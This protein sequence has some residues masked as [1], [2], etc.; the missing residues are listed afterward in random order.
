MKYSKLTT[1]AA[2]IGSLAL[3]ACGSSD[4][5]G[6]RAGAAPKSFNFGDNTAT[7]NAATG[8]VT[9]DGA[10]ASQNGDPVN[11]S[12]GQAF[13]ARSAD[14][15]FFTSIAGD[16]MT[17]AM[18]SVSVSGAKR[19]GQVFGTEGTSNAPNS[20][21]ATYTGDY[22]GTITTTG[23]SQAVT[24]T[25]TGDVTIGAD[26]SSNTFQGNINN[27]VSFATSGSQRGV[28]DTVGFSG[29]ISS[30]LSFQGA[31]SGGALTEGSRVYT[32]SNGLIRGVIG[33][34]QGQSAAGVFEM[35]HTSGVTYT[36]RG[37]FVASSN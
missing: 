22:A 23:S 7:Y 10:T 37:A 15:V 32:G 14:G 16:G 4:P 27:R 3:S 20:T 17:Y 2:L 5:A 13:V 25:I 1:S 29:R 21:F 12:N 19:S 28:G 8:I 34:D 30:D 11:K 18:S 33:G 36:E 35:D 31:A 24:D 6:T 9:L 26:F